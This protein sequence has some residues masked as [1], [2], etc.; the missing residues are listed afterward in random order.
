MME[1]TY[2]TKDF[3][4]GYEIEWGDIPKSIEIP[5]E[6][7]FWEYSEVDIVNIRDPYK[8]IAVDP[9]GEEVPVGGEINTT[10]TRTW[11][12]QVENISKIKQIFLENNYEPSASCVNQGHIH[13]GIPG[14][15]ED[16]DALKRLVAYNK[17]NLPLVVELVYGFKKHPEMT[18]LK[19]ATS[20]LKGDGG[21]VMPEWMSDN[22][23][24][25]ATCFEDFILLHQKGKSGL[26]QEVKSRPFR[27]AINT[28]GLKHSDTLE[29]RFFRSSTDMER[30][31]DSFRFVEA[32]LD[33]ALNTG[34]PAKEILEEGNFLFPLFYWDKEEY[35]G[36]ISTKYP[37]SRGNK[38]RMFR[39]VEV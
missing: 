17:K 22:I 6:L 12:E 28:Y 23:L 14:L 9:L 21:R 24:N 31:K 30:I 20:Y 29:F 3:T 11:Q 36:W 7:G 32:Y 1:R 8:Y 10:P 19:Q 38:S 39:E 18:K 27:Y 4:W 16:I 2:N 15:K 34:K 35:S 26:A 25:Q 33:A 13:V 37:K 5:P